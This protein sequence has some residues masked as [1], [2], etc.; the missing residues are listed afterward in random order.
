MPF[1]YDLV[2]LNISLFSQVYCKVTS[3]IT[4]HLEAL[5]GFFQIAYE[6]DFRSVYTVA[7]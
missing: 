3:S 5:H 7:F 4:S 6:G 2:G 1:N